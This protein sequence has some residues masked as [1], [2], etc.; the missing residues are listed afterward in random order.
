LTEYLKR[1]CDSTVTRTTSKGNDERSANVPSSRRKD[2]DLV[3]EF[4]EYIG[5]NLGMI[6]RALV[7]EHFDDA[8]LMMW[9]ETLGAAKAIVAVGLQ[10]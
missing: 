10:V 2:T 6:G 8:I 3:G 1:I 5:E 7:S 9:E 4:L